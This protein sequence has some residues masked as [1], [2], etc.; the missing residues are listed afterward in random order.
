MGKDSAKLAKALATGGLVQEE[1]DFVPASIRYADGKAKVKIRLKGDHLDH[2]EGDKWSFRVK[3]RSKD[4][5]YG[6][7]R[8]SLQKPEAREFQLTPMMLALTK[9]LGLIPSR[10]MFVDLTING[11]HIGTMALEEHP[12]KEML[13]ASGR[14][15]SVI[16]RFNEKYFW[17]WYNKGASAASSFNPFNDYRFAPIDAF[18]SSRHQEISDLVTQSRRRCRAAEGVR[19]G[20]PT[21]FGG[22]R[23]RA[24]GTVPGGF[25]AVRRLA[26]HPLAQS[27]LLFQSRWRPRS[28]SRCRS[29]SAASSNGDRS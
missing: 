15:D 23:H 22:F 9:S 5:V 7:R 21:R 29:I 3:T 26:R 13:E 28:S 20:P 24:D 2:L 18:Q 11:N 14:K 16:I 17:N 25:R 10:Y 19:R 6:M 1:G 27:A 12:A 4:H 8:F